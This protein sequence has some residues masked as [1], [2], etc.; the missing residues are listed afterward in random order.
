MIAKRFVPSP[1]RGAL[2]ARRLGAAALLASSVL[3]CNWTTFDDLEAEAWAVSFEKPDNDASNWG[4]AIANSQRSGAGG[5][6]GVIGASQALYNELSVASTG[7]VSVAANELELNSQ[8]GIGNLD[9]SPIFIGD[10]S[11]V[12]DDTALVTGSG[13]AIV[14]LRGEHGDL[15]AEQI[16]G[17]DKP[18]AATYL[19]PPPLPGKPVLGPK[20]LV[21]Q[22]DIVYGNHNNM[23]E[24]I[25]QGIVPACKLEDDTAEAAPVIVRALGSFRSTG[26]HDHVIVW[27]SSGRVLIYDGAIWNG[28]QQNV[29][30]TEGVAPIGPASLDT[31]FTPVAGSQIL[32]FD[33]ADG[34]YAVLQGHNEA[35]AGYLAV[36]DLTTLTLVGAVHS[37]TGLRTAALMK[38]TDKFYVVGGYPNTVIDGVSSGQVQVYEASPTAGIGG[39]SVLTLQDAQ[40]EDDQAFGRSVAVMVFNDKPVI[41]VAADNE[42]FL[43]F[44]TNLYDD[45]R[46]GR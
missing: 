14:V 46:S 8:F 21:A 27:G 31:A 2:R 23:D 18:A 13:N 24:G 7:E 16:F 4:V 42:V 38:T 20:V 40:P 44:R 1:R 12:S 43:Y 10:R 5:R 34:H 11:G 32:P 6:L 29:A 41:A 17:K 28:E 25:P 19:I 3:A 45:T 9:P 37:D 26:E 15:D 36:I 35:D 30:C 22:D 39:T 33:T